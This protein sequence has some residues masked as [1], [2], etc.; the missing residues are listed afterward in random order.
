METF[1]VYRRK[2]CEKEVPLTCE[3]ANNKYTNKSIWFTQKSAWVIQF[4]EAWPHL[5]WWFYSDSDSMFHVKRERERSEEDKHTCVYFLYCIDRC[6]RWFLNHNNYNAWNI[7]SSFH[8]TWLLCT[9]QLLL[10]RWDHMRLQN[11]P[12]NRISNVWN[13]SE[14]AS[15]QGNRTHTRHIVAN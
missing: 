2:M 9:F 12:K 11:R 6:K 15:E 5:I 3:R 13:W 14:S 1:S 7:T 4:E 8:R 10:C